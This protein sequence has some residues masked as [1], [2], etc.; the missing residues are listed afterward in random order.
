MSWAE[1]NTAILNT[2]VVAAGV[3][4]LTLPTALMLAI[5]IV[6]TDIVGGR[7]AWLA[8]F[9]QFVVP[10][11]AQVGAWSAGFGT[12]GWWP[13]SQVAVAGNTRAGLAA[14]T[15][16]HAVSTLPSAVLILTLG[17][18]WT[19][20]SREEL[21]LIDG[22]IMH[23]VT[24]VLLPGLRGWIAAAGLWAIVPVMT[25]M[26]VTNL[27]Q[28]PTLPEQIYLDISLG[29]ATA[30][31]YFVS[32][33]LCMLPLLVLAW[34][35]RRWIPEL[36]SFATQ[37]SQHPPARLPLRRWR[38]PATLGVWMIVFA[39]VAIPSINLLIRAG[40]QASLDP[41]GVMRHSWTVNRLLRT[42]WETLTL[43]SSEFRWS[44]TLASASSLTAIF[45]AAGLRATC[46]SR[47][48][49][50]AINWGALI[51]I[52][53]PGPLVASLMTRL[54]LQSSLSGLSWF[55]D[56]SLLAPVLAQQSRLLPLA[57]LLVGGILS[58]VSMQSRELAA[59]DRLPRWS[60]FLTIVWRPTWRLWLAA[61]LLLA[62]TSAGELSTHLLLLPPGVTTV[63]QRL[64][65]FLHF[66]MRY[67]DS[68]LCLALVMLGWLVAIVVWNTRTGRA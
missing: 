3:L 59:I 4:L 30:R 14:V 19:R 37:I 49:R 31:T 7:W 52:V 23:L 1:L 25:E 11:Y 18:N 16:I 61:W 58:T 67:Q 41:S 56:H 57:W 32:I 29:T 13:L 63:A 68:G 5:T 20:R 44:A 36:S 8:L 55:Y 34:L 17:L 48:M 39:V 40:W 10:L 45:V 43:F 6:R 27:Y 50:H 2:L 51:L 21:A 64:F 35:L 33:A 12:Q 54:F 46:K 62:A 53:M 60:H 65:E 24:R 22:G 38:W 15:F 66:G 47:A 28:V 9:S 26:V 42:L